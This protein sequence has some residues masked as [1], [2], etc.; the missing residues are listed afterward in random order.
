MQIPLQIESSR[1]QNLIHQQYN[2]FLSKCIA[3]KRG[4][5]LLELWVDMIIIYVAH[6]LLHICQHVPEI[7]LIPLYYGL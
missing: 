5:M 3:M 4:L 6:T 1:L 2:N 7:F